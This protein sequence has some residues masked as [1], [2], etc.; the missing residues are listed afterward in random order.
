MNCCWPNWATL[1]FAGEH[2]GAV[3]HEAHVET[4]GMLDL[5]LEGR[6]HVTLLVEHSQVEVVVVVGD[7]H[8]AVRVDAD[9]DRVVGDA[10]AAY[11]TQKVSLVV[12]DLDAVGPVVA[13][14]Y[15]VA[16]VRAA[17]AVRKLQVLGTIELVEHG[18]RQIEDDHAHHLALDHNDSVLGVDADAARMLQ[19]VGAKLAYKLS[20]LVRS[21]TTMSPV[22]LTTATRFGYSNWPSRLPHSPNLNLKRPSLSNIWMRCE[23]VSATMMSLLAPIETPLGSVNWP[24]VTPN[25]PNLQLYVIFSRFICDLAGSG[26]DAA[27]DKL[28]SSYDDAAAVI[29]KLPCWSLDDRV[30]DDDSMVAFELR[31]DCCEPSSIWSNGD[32]IFV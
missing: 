8:F 13:D 20:V 15:F 28:D 24:S 5:G 2:N 14:E 17:A 10:L 1:V 12:E 30:D 26:L 4:L 16:I 32:E 11:L 21:V 3:V 23:L 29:S 9:A 25:S 19:Y 6:D 27:A 18:A 7:E 22:C 31:L